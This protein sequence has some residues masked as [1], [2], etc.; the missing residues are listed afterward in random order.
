MQKK[1][2]NKDIKKFLIFNRCGEF[3]GGVGGDFSWA[4]DR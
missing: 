2:N 4:G 3:S 1:G